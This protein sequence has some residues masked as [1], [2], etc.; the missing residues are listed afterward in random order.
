MVPSCVCLICY[1]TENWN[2]F[3]TFLKNH[4]HSAKIP[5]TRIK[6]T[7]FSKP[8]IESA[9]CQRCCKKSSFFQWTSSIR[10]S[11]VCGKK[12][13]FLTLTP[14]FPEGISPNGEV[15][16]A[17]ICCAVSLIFLYSTTTHLY[18]SSVQKKGLIYYITRSFLV[19]S[20]K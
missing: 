12:T 15:V 3:S 18:Y 6:R 13:R 7:L 10:I 20:K 11:L 8:P 19:R 4:L 14:N 1:F 16:V 9:Y 5:W 2:F 17:T